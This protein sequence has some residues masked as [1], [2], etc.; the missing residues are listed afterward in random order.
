MSN[1]RPISL[2]CVLS[3]IMERMLSRKI[4]VHLQT[5]SL[6]HRS[7]HGFCRS[8]FTLWTLSTTY[9]VTNCETWPTHRERVRSAH[10]RSQNTVCGGQI[11][12]KG[13]GGVLGEGQRAPT[14][15][16]FWNHSQLLKVVIAKQICAGSSGGIF[17]LIQRFT[18]TNLTDNGTTSNVICLEI[19]SF[20]RW[21]WSSDI[22]STEKWMIKMLTAA[23][24][25]KLR[26]LPSSKT[27]GENGPARL[28][29]LIHITN[30]RKWSQSERIAS[31]LACKIQIALTSMQFVEH[32]KGVIVDY[33][34]I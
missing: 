2:T 29:M 1:Y 9:E 32:L 5:N 20:I 8:S 15:N 34:V 4:H 25:K 31:G 33:Q 10:A 11:S 3:K 30:E 28:I 7:Q 27:N 17:T 12:R 24:Q 22:K 6:L 26:R 23:V 19:L 18:V 14:A 16:A 13:W 21:Y